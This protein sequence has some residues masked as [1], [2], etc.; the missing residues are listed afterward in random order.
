MLSL[1]LSTIARSRARRVVT[2]SIFGTGSA[3]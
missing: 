2:G 3:A 1:L